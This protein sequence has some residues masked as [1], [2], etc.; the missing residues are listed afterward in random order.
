ML[1][2]CK[3]SEGSIGQQFY[4]DGEIGVLSL[5]ADN[6]YCVAVDSYDNGANI[7]LEYCGAMSVVSWA[8]ESGY[9]KDERFGKCMA[10]ESNTGADGQN[11]LLWSCNDDGYGS[12]RTWSY[13]IR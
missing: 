10:V 3:G 8:Y 7:K 13:F 1:W 2:S 4:R 5:V 11:V 9:F 6:R 12:Y